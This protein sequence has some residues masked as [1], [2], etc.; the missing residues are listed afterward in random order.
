VEEPRERG[1]EMGERG[2]GMVREAERERIRG[3]EGIRGGAGGD[4]Q[5]GREGERES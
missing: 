1:G 5:R 2:R 3:R 4:S